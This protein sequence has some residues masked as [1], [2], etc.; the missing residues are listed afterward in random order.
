MAF[1]LMQ[2]FFLLVQNNNDLMQQNGSALDMLLLC[3]NLFLKKYSLWKKKNR[4][5][6]GNS[7][8][9]NIIYFLYFTL[10]MG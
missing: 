4:K 10:K 3:F 5:N 6:I 7:C 1:A 8:I 2:I 9:Y